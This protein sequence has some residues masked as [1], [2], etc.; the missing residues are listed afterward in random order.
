MT[1][2]GQMCLMGRKYDRIAPLLL[3][4]ENVEKTTMMHPLLHRY[5]EQEQEKTMAAHKNR[6]SYR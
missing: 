2:T 3:L 5:N 6:Q 1:T 4:T